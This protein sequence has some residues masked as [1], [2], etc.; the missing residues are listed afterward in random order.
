MQYSK[1]PIDKILLSCD[2]PRL[3]QSFNEIESIINMI[4]DQHEK[5]VVL[6]KDIIDNGLSPIDSIAVIPLED[7]NGFYEVCEGNRRICVLKILQNPTLIK[8]IDD[9]L[10]KKFSDL[11]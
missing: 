9:G 1:L 5:L 8:D 3:E 11:A 6:A 7:N 2:N 10:Y 4:N